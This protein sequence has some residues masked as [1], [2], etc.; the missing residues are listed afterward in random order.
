MNADTK[1]H[2][3][4]L[5]D[6]RTR[7]GFA[8]F[9]WIAG[10]VLLSLA[11]GAHAAAVRDLLSAR[12]LSRLTQFLSEEVLP[13]PLRT[14]PIDTAALAAWCSEFLSEL[15][16]PALSS[17]LPIASYAI[18]LA[19]V[20]G[21]VAALLGSGPRADGDC[22]GV[23]RK[24][25]R[26]FVRI[27]SVL[28]RAIPEYVLAFCLLGLLGG[29]A[30]P[31]ILALALHNAGI[32]GR[33]GAEAVEDL[34]GRPLRG[35]RSTGASEPQIHLIGTLPAVLGRF[36]LYYFYRFEMALR[37][38]TVLG[39]L[40]IVSLGYFVEEARAHQRYDQVVALMVLAMG[41]ILGADLVSVRARR[42][43]G[44]SSNH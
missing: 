24:T 28:A 43:L 35:L 38:S 5:R 19:G 27:A 41:L 9:T 30:W 22:G 13:A 18:F 4:R 1:R 34:E 2:V 20:L 23:L 25:V 31:A 6:L 44:A 36:L 42:W 37:E 7:N 40:G 3:E 12:R 10:I 21:L 17:T 32:L 14:W 33:L 16:W 39:L 29:G 11:W 8:R 26:H 15:G